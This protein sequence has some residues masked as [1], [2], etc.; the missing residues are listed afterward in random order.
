MLWCDG[1]ACAAPSPPTRRRRRRRPV[2]SYAQSRRNMALRLLNDRAQSRRCWETASWEF[3]TT[4]PDRLG[5]N[6]RLQLLG[7]LR[8]YYSAKAGGVVWSLRSVIRSVCEQDNMVGMSKGWPSRSVQFRCWSG[9]GCGSRISSSLSLTLADRHF[10]RA[11]LCKLGLCHNAVCVCLSVCLCVSP[12][13]SYILSKRIK[14]SSK[15]VHR[16]VAKPF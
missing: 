1:F 7:T 8:Y 14:M 3:L 10:C 13:R 12:S 16:R 5:P 4:D 2:S 11:M 9:F 6:Q 15:F